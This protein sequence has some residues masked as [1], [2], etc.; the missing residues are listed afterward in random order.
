MD[1]KEIL[2]MSAS[3]RILLA[4]E[5]WDSVPEN[6]IELSESVKQELDNR[7]KI[8][9]N[10]EMKYYSIDEVQKKLAQEKK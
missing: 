3:K 6:S 9:E 1:I 7:I 10:G 4:Q 2:K 5:I 8:H